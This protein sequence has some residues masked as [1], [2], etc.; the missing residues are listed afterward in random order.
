LQVQVLPGILAINPADC[1]TCKPVPLRTERPQK[2]ESL[3]DWEPYRL[4]VSAPGGGG[5]AARRSAAEP[6]IPGPT[7]ST[8]SA[9]ASAENGSRGAVHSRLSPPGHRHRMPLG[10]SAG[11]ALPPTSPPRGHAAP[12][13]VRPAQEQSRPSRGPTPAR[14]S[15]TRSTP[16]IRGCR[17][18]SRPPWGSARC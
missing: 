8:G 11:G 3:P 12:S 15:R 18:T 1:A 17:K 7:L 2:A 5:R 6:A 16:P 13:G 14:R 4:P 10:R 9:E